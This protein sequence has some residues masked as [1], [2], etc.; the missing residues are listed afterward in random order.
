[1][2]LSVTCI[3]WLSCNR[4]VVDLLLNT[5]SFAGDSVIF[6]CGCRHRHHCCC[7]YCCLSCVIIVVVA[8]GTVD[9]ART[10]IFL[11]TL[12]L[13]VVVGCC[14][15]SLVS[16]DAVFDWLF[17]ASDPTYPL[18]FQCSSSERL[19]SCL[20]TFMFVCLGESA[21]LILVH[22]QSHLVFMCECFTHSLR[23]SAYIHTTAF[24]QS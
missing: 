10:V 19:G 21:S 6:H 8:V 22:S 11:T 4:L 18:H 14:Q 12:L 23:S 7:F 9:I 24:T 3:L 20:P 16:P 13:S 5:R 17:V 1:M 15:S 2:L